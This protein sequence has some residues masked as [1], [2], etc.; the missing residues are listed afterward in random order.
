MSM[1]CGR[2]SVGCAARHGET[3]LR[4]GALRK[5]RQHGTSLLGDINREDRLMRVSNGRWDDEESDIRM[6]E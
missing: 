5:H 2:A 3:P 1:S 6:N 4:S